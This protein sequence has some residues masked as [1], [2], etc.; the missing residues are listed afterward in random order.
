MVDIND[1]E[2]AQIKRIIDRKISFMFTICN[3]AFRRSDKDYFIDL[4]QTLLK[5]RGD[6]IPNYKP[7]SRQTLGDSVLTS[8]HKFLDNKKKLLSNTDSILIADGWKNKVTDKKFWVFTLR[9]IT[10]N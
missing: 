6:K 7:P 8:A 10:V 2:P 3:I 1:L 9:N 5:V 4:V